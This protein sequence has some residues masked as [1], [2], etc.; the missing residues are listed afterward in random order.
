MS[1]LHIIFYMILKKYRFDPYQVVKK[2]IS[3]YER[4]IIITE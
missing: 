3:I 1:L 4:T 2:Y